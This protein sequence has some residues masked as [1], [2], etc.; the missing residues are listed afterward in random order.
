MPKVSIEQLIDKNKKDIIDDYFTF[1]KYPSISSEPEYKKEVLACALWLRDYLKKLRFHVELWPTEG[2]PTI[3]ASNLDAGPEKPTLL[4][5]NHYDVQPV[6]PIEKWHSPPFTPT[7]AKG[8]VYARGAQDNKGQCFYVLQALKLLL[9]RDGALPINVKWCIDGEEE[10]GS[11]GLSTLLPKKHK[12]L[13]ADYLAVIDLGL[14]NVKVPAV[15]LGVRGIVTMDVELTGGTT[16][17]HSGTHGGIAYNPNH[18]LVELLA[19]LRDSK[20]RVTVP[21][22]YDDVSVLSKK[23]KELLAFDFDADQFAKD[24][25]AEPLGGEQQFTPLERAWTRPTLEING[26]SGGYAGAGFKTVIPAVASAKISCRVVPDQDPEQ[27]GKL[28]A[29]HLKKAAPKGM[30]VSVHLHPGA[31]KAARASLK[32]KIVQATAEAYEEVFQ[33]PCEYIFEGGSIP[34]APALAKASQSEMVL[35]GLGAS[36]DLIHAPNEHFSIDRIEKGIRIITR[37]LELLS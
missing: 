37:L 2:H 4:I 6:D 24:T 14:R 27:I 5:Y 1:L 29:N 15:T 34:I 23:D 20:G 36:S 17:L 26:I 7:V 19:S 16:D 13:R 9:K 30:K 21:G 28:V 35:F 25:G 11:P 31:G 32:S 18:A 12:E 22:F 10:I 8:A 33:K 3:F